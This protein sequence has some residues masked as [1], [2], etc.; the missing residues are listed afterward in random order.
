MDTSKFKHV[1]CNPTEQLKQR[2]NKLIE[3]LNTAHDDIKL[4]K[5]IGDYKPGY[6][7]GNVKTHKM[8]NP[9]RPIISQISVPTYNLAKKLNQIISPYIPDQFSLKSSTDLIDLLQTNK[10][11]VIIAS[12]DVENLFTNVPINDTI[13]IILHEAYN[14]PYLPPPKIPP[15]ILGELLKLCTKEAPF[16]CPRGKLHVQIGVAMGSPLGPTFANYYMG[17]LEKKYLVNRT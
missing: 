2:A 14:H 5:I 4:P 12:L 8:G 9:L 7:Y 11:E 3:A 15:Y 16:R 1:T 6:I 13:S 17:D 10:R